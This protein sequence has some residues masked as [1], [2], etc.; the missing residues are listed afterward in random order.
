MAHRDIYTRGIAHK[1]PSLQPLPQLSAGR[2]SEH[3]A[4]R[5]KVT[6]LTPGRAHPVAVVQ[7]DRPE[8]PPDGA[9]ACRLVHRELARSG[10]SYPCGA[11]AE[12][13][14]AGATGVRKE[15]QESRRH[16]R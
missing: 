16:N 15:V 2:R 1:L 5:S 11:T 6:C 8:R 7:A 4:W 13:P 14:S 9:N 10:S 12:H 3:L